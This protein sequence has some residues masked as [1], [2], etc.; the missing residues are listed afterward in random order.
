MTYAVNTDVATLLGRTLTA[1]EEGKVDVI[2]EV[3][4][5]AIDDHLNGRTADATLLKHVATMAARRLFTLPDGIRQEVLGDWQASYA[6]AEYLNAD[7]RRLLDSGVGTGG[8]R[9]RRAVS[10][11][12]PADIWTPTATA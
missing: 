9:R 8:I 3:V 11:T 10:V 2:L 6:P 4:D 5:L 12:I 7:E 1:A